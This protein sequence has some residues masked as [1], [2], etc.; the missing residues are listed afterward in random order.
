MVDDVIACL[1]LRNPAKRPEN[2]RFGSTPVLTAPKRDFRSS[3]INGHHRTLCITS[4]D[5]WFCD[6]KLPP[7]V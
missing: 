4:S 6:D 7:S 5:R 2:V 1:A 3:V